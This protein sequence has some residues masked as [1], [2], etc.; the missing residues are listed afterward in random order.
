MK[1]S[2]KHPLSI[3]PKG[4]E[5][6]RNK[7]QGKI[8][9]FSGPSGVG[10]GTVINY[11]REKYKD[12]WIFPPSCTTRAPR[13]GEKEGETYFFLTKEEFEKKIEAGEFLEYAHVHGETYYGTLKQRLLEPL[14]EGKI[15]VREFDVQG[16]V[17]AKEKL[18]KESYVSIF[19]QPAEGLETLVRRIKERAPITEEELEKRKISMGKELKLAEIYDYRIDSYDKDLER[20]FADVEK[21]IAGELE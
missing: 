6:N 7:K 9:F 10:K 2:K 19:I 21:I 13:P 15:V 3:S 17:Q 5:D 20:L 1:K 18:P 4:R 14:K 16:F 11:L 12:E 8:F